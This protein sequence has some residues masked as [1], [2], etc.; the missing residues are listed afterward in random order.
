MTTSVDPELYREAVAELARLKR[1]AEETAGMIPKLYASALEE[2]AARLGI[3][4][5]RLD[6]M[7]RQEGGDSGGA[8]ELP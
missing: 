1:P 6:E 7:V 8:A 3:E 2:W 4:A 5:A